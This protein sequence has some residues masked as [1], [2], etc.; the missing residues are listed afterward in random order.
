[1][2][3]NNET[4][5]SFACDHCDKRFNRKEN[6]TRHLKNHGD[7]IHICDVCSKAFTRSDLLKRHVALHSTVEEDASGEN[8]SAKR[9]KH[10]HSRGDPMGVQDMS[11][12][13]QMDRVGM[14]RSPAQAQGPSRASQGISSDQGTALSNPRLPADDN[15]WASWPFDLPSYDSRSEFSGSR[16]RCYTFR[17]SRSRRL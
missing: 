8:L 12:G 6:L 14:G 17:L 15:F 3:V 9:R 1:M 13:V 2:P 11:P 7:K 16:G 10:S 4:Q 5:E